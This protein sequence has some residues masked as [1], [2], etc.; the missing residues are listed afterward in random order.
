MVEHLLDHIM[1]PNTELK[2]EVNI[3]RSSQLS[4]FVKASTYLSTV[5]VYLHAIQVIHI[6]M[7][8]IERNFGQKQ[9]QSLGLKREW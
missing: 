4:T 7:L 5:V 6:L 2:T 8:N 1:P 9:A 3:C